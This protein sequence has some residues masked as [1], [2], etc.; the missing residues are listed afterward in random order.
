MAYT[1][2]MKSGI[3]A[4]TGQE[5]PANSE[6]TG[7]IEHQ[8]RGGFS[9]SAPGTLSKKIQGSMDNSD[10][11][12][13]WDDTGGKS[14]TTPVRGGSSGSSIRQPSSYSPQGKG[15]KVNG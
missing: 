8:K 15:I 10:P 13:D 3:V 6:R 11:E 1:E 12:L 7:V 4:R 14:E 2:S 5:D 9:I